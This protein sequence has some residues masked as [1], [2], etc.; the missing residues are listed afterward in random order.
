MAE[1]A[2]DANGL[3]RP[4]VVEEAGHTDDHVKF[5]QGQRRPGVIK[6]DGAVFQI[7]R[8]GFWKCISIYSQANGKGRV[9]TYPRPDAPVVGPGNRLMEFQGVAPKGL[10][11]ERV[12]PKDSPA[13]YKQVSR[14]LEG[15]MLAK[16]K[17][18][19]SRSAGN[20]LSKFL[21]VVGSS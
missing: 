6:I 18:K 17:N 7:P 20:R 3:Q 16:R 11:A 21:A 9:W 10:I 14:V 15:G 1:R 2:L 8:Q 5:K 19:P 4:V 12:K 13:F